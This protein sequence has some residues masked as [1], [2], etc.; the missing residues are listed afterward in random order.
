MAMFYKNAEIFVSKPG[1][2][3]LVFTDDKGVETRE[4]IA[5][6]DG[7][8]TGVLQGMHNLTSSITSFAISCFEYAL[9]QKS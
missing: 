1:K 8:S 2:A 9:D 5:E 3:E 7:K 6:F 4:F